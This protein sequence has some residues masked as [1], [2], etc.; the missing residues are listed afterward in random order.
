MS[1]RRPVAHPLGEEWRVGAILVTIG[2]FGWWVAIPYATLVGLH[3]ADADGGHTGIA[4][5]LGLLGALGGVLFTGAGLLLASHPRRI[6]LAG[7]IELAVG[8]L[9]LVLTSI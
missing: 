2:A 7:A 3:G 5:M 6:A 9:A 8:A 4:I 1:V